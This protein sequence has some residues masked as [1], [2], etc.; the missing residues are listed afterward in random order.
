MLLWA[1]ACGVGLDVA[2]VALADPCG[3][4][5]PPR[6]AVFSGQVRYVGDGD[7]LCVGTTGDPNTWIEVRLADFYAPELHEPGG[8]MAKTELSR[9]A[10]GRTL[11]CE[12]GKRSYDR[13]VA[14]CVLSGSRVGDLMRRAG[15]LEGGRGR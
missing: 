1:V 7:S 12:A 2:G 8:L 5:L 13:V 14:Q 9:I 6:G 11:Q 3:G 15:V 10:L 4:P